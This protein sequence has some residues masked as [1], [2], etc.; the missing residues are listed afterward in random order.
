MLQGKRA[1]VAGCSIVYVVVNKVDS[2]TAYCC[3]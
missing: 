3:N 1:D 2:F